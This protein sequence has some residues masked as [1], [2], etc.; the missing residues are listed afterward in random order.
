MA[1]EGDLGAGK[2][3]FA[4]GMGSGLGVP[5]AITG[6]TFTLTKYRGRVPFF[7]VDLFRLSG[8]AG[9]GEAEAGVIGLEEYLGG[10]RVTPPWSGRSGPRAPAP[11][12]H[13]GAALSGRRCTAAPESLTASGQRS[14][15][16][17]E[18]LTARLSD[19]G[20]TGARE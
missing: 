3:V 14:T 7:H 11:R 18:A 10:D 19:Q 8:E 4:Q 9:A 17:L 2:T 6:P 15:T 1:L 20:R 5:D 12:P 13:P 16:T